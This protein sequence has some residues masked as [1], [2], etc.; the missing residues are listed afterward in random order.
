M[1]KDGKVFPDQLNSKNLWTFFP[2]TVNTKQKDATGPP[3]SLML[4]GV[5][6]GMPG[7]LEMVRTKCQPKS[8]SG[9]NANHRKKSY[10]KCQPRL[11]FCPVGIL[12]GWHLVH[13]PKGQRFW[14]FAICTLWPLGLRSIFCLIAR[15]FCFFSHLI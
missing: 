7:H 5:G 1:V 6:G 13:T 9:Q 8:W 4:G 15:L 12:S 3:H 2:T 14:K 11:A 10:T